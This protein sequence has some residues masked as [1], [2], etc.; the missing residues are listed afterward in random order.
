MTAI[1]SH[2]KPKP[3]WLRKHLPVRPEFEEI[4]TLLKH[5]SLNTVCESAKCPNIWECFSK[6]T[7]TFLIMGNRCTRDCRFCAIEQGPMGLPDPGEPVHVAEAV[8]KMGLEHAVITSVTRDDL[9]DFGVS[10]FVKTIQEIQ[11]HS[12][13]IAIEVLVPDFSGDEKAIESLIEAEPDVIGHNIETVPGLYPIVRPQ[14]RYRISL[15][16]LGQV[17]ASAKNIFVK[18]GLMLGLGETEDEIL[19]TLDDLLGS[20]CRILTLGQYL[21]P[22]KNHIPVNRFITPE[23]FHAW[24]EKALEMGFRQVVSGPFVRSSYHAG[25]LF[26]TLK[27]PGKRKAPVQGLE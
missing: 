19:R 17:S 15:S 7:A 23:E 13:G 25:E 27:A 14:A 10:C 18:S 24:Q 22:T 26:R 8:Q 4:R 21:Q 16:L 12:P 9:A 3:P 6:K 1:R 11:K 5:S 2:R 20:G